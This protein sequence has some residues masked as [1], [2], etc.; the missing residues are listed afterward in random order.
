M[1]VSHEPLRTACCKVATESGDQICA[2]PR[3]RKRYSPPTSSALRSTGSSPKA[4]GVAADRLGRDLFEA[5]AFDQRRGAGEIL[6]HEVRLQP[7]RV[8]YLRAAIG[9][10][11]RD[12]HLGHHLEDA[13]A[14][15]LDVAVDDLVG[16]DLRR[17]L[18]APVHVGERVEGE[19]GVDRLG[20]V[21][22]EAAEMVHLARL[23]GFHHEADRR[24]QAL[25][26][27]MVVHGRGGEQRRYRDAVRPDLAVRQDDDVVAAG[28][29][30]FRALAEPLERA[31]H[32]GRTF[33]RQ[34]R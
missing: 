13:L 9:L 3:M 5:D 34:H 30:R 18:A 20:A 6:L 8:E 19:I 25:A 22:G 11:G 15:R 14:D 4:L 17:Q 21:T 24:A 23:A 31:R 32:A 12:A 27:Q 33:G 16:V 28:D 7:D 1:K 10:V 2:S 29:C 26:D